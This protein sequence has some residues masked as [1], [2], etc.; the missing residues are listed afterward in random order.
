[1]ARLRVT[2]PKLAFARDERG[3]IM[4]L[5]V[6]F[7][8]FGIAILYLTVGAG[9]S[10]LFR[11]HVQD[12]A[13]S[14]ALSG[15][16][17]HARMM[18][19]LVLINIIM[20]ALLAILVAIKTIESLATIGIIIAGGLSFI[21]FGASLLAIPPLTA[22]RSSMVSAYNAA[23]PPI[24]SGLDVLQSASDVIAKVGPVISVAVVQSDITAHKQEGIISDGIAASTAIAGAGAAEVGLPV[25]ADAYSKLCGKAGEFAAMVAMKPLEAI[26]MPSK[27]TG[28]IRGAMKELTEALSSWFCDDRGNKV[29]EL[30]QKLDVGFPKQQAQEDACKRDMPPVRPDEVSKYADPAQRPPLP[31]SCQELEDF[32]ARA[33]PDA[34]GNCDRCAGKGDDANCGRSADEGGDANCGP[35]SP[36]ERVVAQARI[37]CDPGNNPQPFNYTYQLQEMRVK[38]AWDGQ[39]WV[40]EKPQVIQSVLVQATN[41]NDKPKAP[42]TREAKEKRYLDGLIVISDPAI[43]AQGYQTKVHPDGDPTTFLPVC[44]TEEEP[45]TPVPHYGVDSAGK[46]IE[47]PVEPEERTFRQVTNIFSCQKNTEVKVLQGNDTSASAEQKDGKAPKRIKSDVV[48]GGEQLQIRAVVLANQQ[49]RESA[50]LVRLGL[51]GEPDPGNP[52]ERLRGLGG[53]AVAQAEYFYQTSDRE[54]GDNDKDKMMWNM[55][56]RARLRRVQLPKDDQAMNNFRGACSAMLGKRGADV[57]RVVEDWEPLLGH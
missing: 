50:R 2:R 53:F 4:V 25:E 28:L 51:W 55:N 47:L 1:M 12:A 33:K 38:Y 23:K 57:L 10:V 29:P 5:A 40:R 48:L 56:W 9:E 26:G 11:E 37:E 44:T 16:I 8:V 14:A 54:T 7:A 3:A 45:P 35:D 42:C 17:A 43:I 36:F 34:Q 20:A 31:P 27:L 19:L 24:F 39:R 18:N 13:D 21:T 15:A 22:L 30:P 49:Q 32:N 46:V 52:L 41:D 6:F